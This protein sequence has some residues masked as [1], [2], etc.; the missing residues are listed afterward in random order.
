MLSLLLHTMFDRYAHPVEDF[1][2][3]SVP[4]IAGPLI[5]GMHAYVFWLWL[6]IRLLET[7][8][9]HSGYSF[10]W[11]PFHLFAFQGGAERHDFHHSHN[12]GCYGSFTI[13]WDWITGTDQAFLDF[14]AKKTTKGDKKH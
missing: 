7:V 11:S 14:K 9:A 12:V 6:C 3:N 4:T 1:L 2:A 5:M 13:F 10:P 8:D